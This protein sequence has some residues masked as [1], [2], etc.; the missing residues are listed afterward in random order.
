MRQKINF[1]ERRQSDLSQFIQ[2]PRI[3]KDGD[4][5]VGLGDAQDK[6]LAQATSNERELKDFLC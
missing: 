1:K 2:F 6:I 3:L 4:P 5:L